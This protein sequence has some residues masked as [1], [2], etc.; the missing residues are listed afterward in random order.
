MTAIFTN[1]DGQK[2]IAMDS[3]AKQ[4]LSLGKVQTQV[5]AKTTFTLAEDY[6]QKYYLRNDAALMK[7]LAKF[8]FS[9]EEFVNSTAV[10]RLSAYV[11]G[12]GDAST[13]ERDL[14]G[15]GLGTDAGRALLARFRR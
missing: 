12:H 6:H 10:A 3:L 7:E 11:G 5:L 14:P 4:R 9:E 1:N 2:R 15:L 13:L 8:H